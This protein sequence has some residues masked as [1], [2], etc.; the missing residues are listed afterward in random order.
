MVRPTSPDAVYL[1]AYI[2]AGGLPPNPLTAGDANCNGAVNI[3]DAVYLIAYIFAG[4]R[5]PC[6]AKIRQLNAVVQYPT[7][8][9]A[10]GGFQLLPL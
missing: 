9:E 6:A 3:S 4:G 1:I 2:F 5:A 10:S 8:I 7:Q